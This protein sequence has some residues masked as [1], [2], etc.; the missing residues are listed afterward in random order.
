MQKYENQLFPPN[1]LFLFHGREFPKILIPFCPMLSPY[2]DN[3]KHIADFDNIIRWQ[4]S[5]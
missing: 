2:Q 1:L 3:H 4:A 5:L